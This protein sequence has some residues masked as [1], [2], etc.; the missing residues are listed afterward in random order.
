MLEESATIIVSTCP[1]AT[2]AFGANKNWSR[3]KQKDGLRANDISSLL[4]WGSL[5]AVTMTSI[6]VTLTIF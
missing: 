5:H 6:G 3:L 2:G 1:W 4:W